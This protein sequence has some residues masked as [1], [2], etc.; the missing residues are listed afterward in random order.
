MRVAPFVVALL[1][2]CAGMDEV[3]CRRANWYDLGFR[4]AIFGILAQDD[5]YA[6]QCDPLGVKVDVAR[7]RQG[8][9]EGTYEADRRR[10]S[11]HD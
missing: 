1:C 6:L 7:Y 5:V 9:R 11:A 8:F 2:G 10:V 3:E 4:D